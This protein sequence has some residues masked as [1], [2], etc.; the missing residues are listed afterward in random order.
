MLDQG[1]SINMEVDQPD[2]VFGVVLAVGV[3]PEPFP[4]QPPHRGCPG[5]AIFQGGSTKG[6]V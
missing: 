3:A 5:E 4:G 6:Q 2:A 1:L